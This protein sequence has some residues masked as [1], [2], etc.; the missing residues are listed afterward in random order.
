[1]QGLFRLRFG[2]ATAVTAALVAIAA[3]V[4][5][6]FG[7]A[8]SSSVGGTL[9]A[10]GTLNDHGAIYTYNLNANE[11]GP[12]EGKGVV[13]FNL[14]GPGL[15]L[16]TVF[17]GQTVSGQSPTYTCGHA[18][19]QAVN[20]DACKATIQAHGF[21]HSDFPFDPI[22]LGTMTVAVEFER[23]GTSIGKMKVTVY[24]PKGKNTVSGD[25][26]FGGIAMSTCP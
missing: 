19:F 2:L 4:L 18:S 8:S 7:G 24:T 17:G 13:G 9:S 26:T 22:Y 10:A 1:M 6:S 21:S 11:T 16:C 23:Q 15:T 25:V 12:E 14:Q 3:L 20:I 5:A